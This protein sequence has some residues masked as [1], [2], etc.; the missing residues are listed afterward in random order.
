MH[1]ANIEERLRSTLRAEGDS[2]PFTITVEEL[3]RRHT[4][5][6]R[7]RSDRRMALMAAAVAAVAVGAIFAFSSGLLR[8]P[9]VG[10]D[11]TPT[12][13]PTSTASPPASPARLA[14]IPE[15]TPSV[16]AVDYKQTSG[17]GDSSGLDDLVKVPLGGVR[18]DATD[19]GVKI[20]CLGPDVPAVSFGTSADP[21][22]IASE[23]IP[24]D[25]N[26]H[27]SRYPVSERQPLID[28][29]VR[30]E[31]G[32]R[33]TYRILVETF[34]AITW[35]DLPPLSLPTPRGTVGVD[36]AGSPDLSSSAGPMLFQTD[37]VPASDGYG[38]ALVCNG[39]GSIDW[40]IGAGRLAGGGEQPC[41][42]VPRL[43]EVA[44]GALSEPTSI[45]VTTHPHNRWR[46]VAA[47]LS[48]PLAFTAPRLFSFAGDATQGNAVALGQCAASKFG[49]DQC[50]LPLRVREGT[51]LVELSPGQ[52]LDVA[53]ADGWRID[54]LAVDA[55]R[56]DV[57]RAD[58]FV[59]T[60]RVTYLSPRADRVS[61]DLGPRERGEWLIRFHVTGSKGGD[62]F[63]AAYD[64]PIVVGG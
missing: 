50:F 11:P 39:T 18:L 40:A 61:V 12:P 26:V 17:E 56:R 42:G 21:A 32:R 38:V 60:E 4:L 45:L 36:H 53:L 29:E 23:Q 52:T 5:R 25:G 2:L 55:I 34:G 1:D 58:A 49:A 9:V 24:C 47:A 19:V 33:T 30:L 54:E 41:D 44:E 7:S 22:L 63:S 64:V 13:E 10:D 6:R 27:E 62:S 59:E 8:G 3:E 48:G 16:D 37:P 35:S 20:V 28:A 31:V 43:S 46:I 14:S 51:P 57:A 15:L